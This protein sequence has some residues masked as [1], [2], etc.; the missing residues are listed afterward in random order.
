MLL[1]YALSPS[2]SD[3]GCWDLLLLLLLTWKT[4]LNMIR[5]EYIFSFY[6]TPSSHGATFSVSWTN[7]PKKIQLL[8]TPTSLSRR[9]KLLW[10]L[11]NSD[12]WQP[13]N[14]SCL[15]LPRHT[16]INEFIYFQIWLP[17]SCILLTM[18]NTDSHSFLILLL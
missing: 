18:L 15:F 12:A 10:L 7:K 1:V 5:V 6:P 8:K 3:T 9:K 13:W 17:Y 4:L 11:L 14:H 2:R 16:F